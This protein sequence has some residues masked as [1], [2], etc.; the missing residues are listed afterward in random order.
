MEEPYFPTKHE[1][2]YLCRQYFSA[3]DPFVHLLSKFVFDLTVDTF[4]D[5]D[6][7]GILA[8]DQTKALILAVCFAAAVSLPFLQCQRYVGTAK[9]ALVEKYKLATEHY[10]HRANVLSTSNLETMQA[11]VIYLVP[12]CRG[13]VSRSSS[14]FVGALVRNAQITGFD[15]E[16]TQMNLS[17]SQSRRLL[18]CQLCFLDLRTAE[19]QGPRPAIQA[20][21]LDLILPWNA[22]DWELNARCPSPASKMGWTDSTFSLI[23]YECYEMHRQIL[24]Y[25]DEIGAGRASLSYV[26]QSVDEG[27]RR[28]EDIYLKHI[29]ERVPVQRCAKLVGKLLL[30]RFDLILFH[31]HLPKTGRSASHLQLRDRL[32]RSSL[33]IV[34]SAAA[35]ETDP[36]LAPWAWYAGAYQQYH[37]LIFLLIELYQTPDLEE[38]DRICAIADYVFGS[39]S[40]VSAG[41]RSGEILRVLKEKLELFP[42]TQGASPIS[43]SFQ[44]QHLD[45]NPELPLQELSIPSMVEESIVWNEWDVQGAVYQ[46][47]AIDPD[48]SFGLIGSDRVPEL[49]STKMLSPI[50]L[51]KS[52]G[53]VRRFPGCGL[54]DS[55]SRVSLR[56]PEGSQWLAASQTILVLT[57][58]A[59]ARGDQQHPIPKH[60]SATRHNMTV[61]TI[62]RAQREA[63]TLPVSQP[64]D[65]LIWMVT[66]PDRRLLQR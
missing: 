15:R 9:S 46:P 6:L 4:Y 14:I 28:I 27:K 20:T 24:H 62:F 16:A 66:D 13:E 58:E 50:R 59:P 64:E 7:N 34:E 1:C 57:F 10:L 31:E 48:Y 47:E 49:S 65:K 38:A 56:A 61:K 41:Q 32:V 54:E 26:A 23:R 17:A 39:S 2:Q 43:Q 51:E 25:Q 11:A 52:R 37:S 8:S 36:D 21:G 33:E 19:A 22:D 5:Q 18:W 12:I 30:A 63:L 3:V 40:G 53:R 45:F 55:L 44:T 42:N 35:L 29:D 60:V